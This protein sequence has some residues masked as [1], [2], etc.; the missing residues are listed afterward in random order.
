[1]SL[2]NTS[3]GRV[4][5]SFAACIISVSSTKANPASTSAVNES[6]ERMENPNPRCLIIDNRTVLIAT[7]IAGT[8]PFPWPTPW[9]GGYRQLPP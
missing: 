3:D 2:L 9:S 8:A 7:Q 1:M 6:E 5:G 4:Y